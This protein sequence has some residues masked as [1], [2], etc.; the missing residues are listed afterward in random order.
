MLSTYFSAERLDLKGLSVCVYVSEY[1]LA[2]YLY[3]DAEHLLGDFVVWTRGSQK[4]QC[5]KVEEPSIC[6]LYDVSE[7][8]TLVFLAACYATVLSLC[9]ECIVRARSRFSYSLRHEANMY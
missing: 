3:I 2:S 7:F 4:L 9:L 6:R 1:G 8:E 5:L